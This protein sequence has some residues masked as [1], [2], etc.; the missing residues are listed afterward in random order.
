MARVPLGALAVDRPQGVRCRGSTTRRHRASC[1][2]LRP[3][4]ARVPS[5]WC[6]A[7]CPRPWR[8]GRANMLVFTAARGRRCGT[9]CGC[10]SLGLHSGRRLMPP[11]GR[12]HRCRSVG[13]GRWRGNCLRFKRPF[14]PGRVVSRWPPRVANPVF[15]SP[16]HI[17][18]KASRL[19]WN[20]C[21]DKKKCVPCV[22]TSDSM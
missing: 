12:P 10:A 21:Q 3:P 20:R 18:A 6:W 11:W 17:V 2:A 15:V 13:H 14:S 4:T 9:A 7:A 19:G 1:G 22:K 8:A 16:W 5:A